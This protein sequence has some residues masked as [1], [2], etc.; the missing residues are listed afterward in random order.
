MNKE[1]IHRYFFQQSPAEVWDYLTRPELLEQWL[2][3]T[4]FQ[5]RI[6]HKFSF[7]SK[8][9]KVTS[10]EVLEIVPGKFLSYSWTVQDPD[11][12]TTVDSKV[13]WTL[14]EKDGGTELFLEHTGFMLSEDFTAHSIGWANCLNSLEKN[15]K[16]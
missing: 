7:I 11:K 14:S 16:S 8:Y 9:Q 2:M 6:G 10:C 4:D 1:I 12:K 15:L 13:H 3:K 5:L